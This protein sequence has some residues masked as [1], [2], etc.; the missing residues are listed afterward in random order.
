MKKLIGSLCLSLTA[1]SVSA[2]ISSDVV[3]LHPNEIPLQNLPKFAV[4]TPYSN[5]YVQSQ[6]KSATT[7]ADVVVFYQPSFV[8]KYGKREAFKRISAWFDLTNQTYQTHDVDFK[9]QIED[10]VP[11][12][13]VD[14]SVPFTDVKDD[15]GNIIVDGSMYLFSGAV[16]NAGSPEY[17]IYQVKWKGDLVVYV[18]EQRE[19]NTTAGLAGIGSEL[20]AVVDFDTDP[21][22]YPTLAHEIGHNLGMNHEEANAFVGPDY[23]RAWICGG[24]KTIMYAN[25]NLSA[26][27]LEHYSTPDMTNGGEACGNET[28]DNARIL[29]ENH[30]AASLRREGVE[31]RG[32]VSFSDI[33]FTGNEV[34]GVTITLE[35]DGDV[36]EAASVKVFAEDDTAMMGQDY[37][38][39]F[40][41]AEFD[42]GSTTSQVQYPIIK[43]SESEDDETFTVHLRFPYKLTLNASNMATLTVVSNATVGNAGMFSISGSAE[44]NEGDVGEYVVTRV[45][46]VGEAVVT[47]QSEGGSARE[48]L[49]FVVL[50][51]ELVF[52]EG[53]TQK[54]VNLVTL[55]D[56]IAETTESMTIELSSSSTTA[57]YDVKSLEVTILDDDVDVSPD[58]GTFALNAS[59]TTISESAG[60]VAITVVRSDGSDGSAVVRVRT[61]EGTALAGEDFTAI[62]KEITFADGETEKTV[63]IQILDD[64]KDEDGTTSFDVILE[65][66]GVEVTT[67]S[68]T[69]TLTDNDDAPVTTTP[70]PTKPVA[71]D[72]SGGGSTGFLMTLLLSMCVFIRRSGLFLK[73]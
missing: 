41:L 69:I 51:E 14:D 3:P 70:T 55:S 36:S 8:A 58:V 19:G 21:T 71:E 59:E 67:G 23:A 64:T 65:G 42:A 31:S 25:V 72:S 29:K 38:D 62:N 56:T 54:S 20:A 50:N 4:K 27:N 18:R 9:L 17:D 28:A 6:T 60:S 10:I 48:G 61:V 35:R 32:A 46:G 63:T 7:V 5:E 52:A 68:V 15:E 30:V 26:T 11:V 44:L 37:T 66:A 13:S 2:Q 49:D 22:T 45:G 73:K 1:L 39:T 40:V 43:D 16:L 24:R 57:E 33:A 47:V 34:D 12:E 53:E